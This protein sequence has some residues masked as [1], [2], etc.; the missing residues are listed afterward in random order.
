MP[1]SQFRNAE[2]D[3][4]CQRI[5]QWKKFQRTPGRAKS[6]A[7]R[8]ERIEFVQQTCKDFYKAFPERDPT[9][10]DPTPL[11]FLKDVVD[12]FE[13]IVQQWYR[14]N[15][16]ETQQAPNDAPKVKD[17]RISA[18]N[19]AMKRFSQAIS[20]IVREICM[21]QPTL[22]K[23]TAFNHATTQYMDKLKKEDSA[24]YDKLVADALEI[25]QASDMD[26]TDLSPETL[27]QYARIPLEGSH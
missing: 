27:A 13:E 18:R 25:C 17:C 6:K 22:D 3:F 10:G 8:R 23:I 20:E 1:P 2:Q 21:E 16:R 19:L 9:V 11:T 26:Y 4:L 7:K 12:D 14:N 24:A 5:P 15:L